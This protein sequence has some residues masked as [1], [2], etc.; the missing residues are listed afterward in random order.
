MASIFCLD[1]DLIRIS[2]GTKV[3]KAETYAPLLTA[4]ATLNRARETAR[5][6]I[7]DAEKIYLKEK[8]RGYQD[9][10]LDGKREMA[11]RLT[12][13]SMKMSQ[14]FAAVEHQTVVLVMNIVK[15]VIDTIPEDELIV[16][17]VRKALTVFKTQKQITVRVAPSQIESVNE[18]LSEILSKYPEINVIDVKGDDRLSSRDLILESEIG[19]VDAGINFQLNTIQETF[20]HYFRQPVPRQSTQE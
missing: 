11:A 15:K 17:L 1:D 19:I 8:Q 13:T 5:T 16:A 10:M 7:E 4:A 2:S 9:G 18:R 6:K 12:E 20:A 14:Y 3:V